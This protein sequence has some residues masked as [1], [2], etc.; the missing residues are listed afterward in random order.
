MTESFAFTIASIF[1]L[2]SNISGYQFL[3]WDKDVPKHIKK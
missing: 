3:I 1:V 2:D